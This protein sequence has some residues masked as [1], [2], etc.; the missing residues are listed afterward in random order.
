MQGSYL[1]VLGGENTGL[2]LI[3]LD[4]YQSDLV[5]T[6]FIDHQD[7][8]CPVSITIAT[9]VDVDINLSIVGN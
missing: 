7:W 5:I 9:I 6:T 1:I 3:P 4:N 2:I 8:P